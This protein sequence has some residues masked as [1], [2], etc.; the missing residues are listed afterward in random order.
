LAASSLALRFS[1]GELRLECVD[2]GGAVLDLGLQ[3]GDVAFEGVHDR[4]I[5]RLGH[6]R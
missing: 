4:R 1:A 3:A 5:D 6:G 2:L